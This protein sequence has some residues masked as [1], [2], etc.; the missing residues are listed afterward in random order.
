VGEDEGRRGPAPDISVR[1]AREHNLRRVDV[2][3]PRGTFAV[4]TGVSGS[5]KSSLAFDTICAEGRRRYLETFSSYTRQF[6]GRIARPAVASLD[7]L[8]PAVAVDQSTT[9]GNPRSTVGTMTELY[10]LLRLLWARAGTAGAGA[11]VP[12]IQRQLFSFNSPHGACPSCKGLGVEDRLDPDLLIADPARSIRGGAL[13]ITTPTGYLIYSQVTLDVLDQVCRAHGFSVDVPWRE[14]TPGQRDIVLNGSDRIRIPYGKH[15]LESRLRW[16]GITAK[17][18]EEGVYKG[19][20]P[21]MEQ[22]LRQ[23]RNDNILRFVRTSPCRACGGT[24]LRPEALAVTVDGRTIAEAAALSID[25]LRAWFEPP[26]DRDRSISGRRREMGPVTDSRE[27]SGTSSPAA[28][29]C[30]ASASA[31]SRSIASRRRSRPAR[32]SASGSRASRASACAACSTCSTS[33]RSAFTTTTRPSCWTCCAA[34]GTRATRCW[35]SS[36]TT[37]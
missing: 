29:C 5:G 26:E 9:V 11:V 12:K 24:R 37:R 35:S 4:V 1:G 33:R 18:R 32:R 15:P 3:I 22:I 25:D 13:R 27:C 31:I 20:L 8:S 16:T 7:G 17:P 10:D 23:K 28:T 34:S 2:D 14:L 19:I 30:S 21:V 36:T 6:L